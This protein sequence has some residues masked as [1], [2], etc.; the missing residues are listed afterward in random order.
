MSE[1]Y[2][3][4]AVPRAEYIDTFHLRD[5][6]DAFI[7]VVERRVDESDLWLYDFLMRNE[8]RVFLVRNKVNIDI[9]SEAEDYSR[10]PA[11]TLGLIREDLAGEFRLG[12]SG[13]VYLIS[14]KLR[15]S[16]RF[17]L[18]RLKSDIGA[19]RKPKLHESTF[20]SKYRAIQF[21]DG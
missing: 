15:D 14:A 12:D 17:D 4:A 1:P 3:T 11:E 10:E 8:K 18:P 16:G 20:Q 21:S 6:Y 7:L 9:L 5:R 13:E 19:S 2:R